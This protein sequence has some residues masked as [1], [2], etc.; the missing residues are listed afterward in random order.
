MTSRTEGA[1]PVVIG[2]LI[3]LLA[4]SACDTGSHSCTGNENENKECVADEDC[5]DEA[6]VCDTESNRCY[7]PCTR[8]RDCVWTHYCIL[9]KGF[10][11]TNKCL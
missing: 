2:L 4:A 3:S 1:A 11:Q 10:C 7:F 8:D 9:E 6:L 5:D